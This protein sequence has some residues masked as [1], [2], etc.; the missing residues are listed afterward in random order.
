MNKSKKKAILSAI[1][2]RHNPQEMSSITEKAFTLYLMA[3]PRLRTCD[4]FEVLNT[5]GSRYLKD[6]NTGYGIFVLNTTTHFLQ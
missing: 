4:Y 5:I 6:V 3:R 2:H 1:Y